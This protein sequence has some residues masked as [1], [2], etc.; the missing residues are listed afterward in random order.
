MNCLAI[1][2]ELYRYFPLLASI[3]KEEEFVSDSHKSVSLRYDRITLAM[4]FNDEKNVSPE[5]FNA[6]FRV[7]DHVVILTE[8]HGVPDEWKDRIWDYLLRNAPKSFDTEIL[9]NS[10]KVDKDVEQYLAIA[11]NIAKQ[12]QGCSQGDDY[13]PGHFSEVIIDDSGIT[14]RQI[15]RWNSRSIIH[16]N[17]YH[18]RDLEFHIP[19]GRSE[20][21][22]RYGIDKI[23]RMA[24]IF[25]DSSSMNN[26]VC[27]DRIYNEIQV[28]KMQFGKSR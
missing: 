28:Q 22:H 9:E 6:K 8:L 17:D 16:K 4:K 10:E 15:N 7:V 14:L 23:G 12:A 27:G 11:D 24:I 2:N 5:Y 1:V 3:E 20:M 26:K 21:D 13:L 25:S 18:M 19:G